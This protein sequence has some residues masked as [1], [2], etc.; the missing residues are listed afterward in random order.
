[1]VLVEGWVG[2]RGIYVWGLLQAHLHILCALR[3]SDHRSIDGSIKR[4]R[5]DQPRPTSK[6]TNDKTYLGDGDGGAD[7]EALAEVRPERLLWL[8]W[9]CIVW[10]R[11]YERHCVWVWSWWGCAVMYLLLET[12]YT[13]KHPIHPTNRPTNKPGCVGGRTHHGDVPKGVHGHDLVLR[14]PILF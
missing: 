5:T 14:P 7:V 12:W 3:S 6:Q 8:F 1:M 10:G 4:T 13:S 9:C 11:S 2:L